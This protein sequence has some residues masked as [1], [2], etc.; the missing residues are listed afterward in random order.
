MDSNRSIYSAQGAPWRA[1]TPRPLRVPR[2]FTPDEARAPL[3]QCDEDIEHPEENHCNKEWSEVCQSMQG[4][5]E[6]GDAS[7]IGDQDQR[8]DASRSGPCLDL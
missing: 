4:T 3:E 7:V 1:Q 2:S 8:H 6:H 5:G